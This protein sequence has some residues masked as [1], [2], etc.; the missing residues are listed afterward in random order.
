MF[1][2]LWNRLYTPYHTPFA[3]KVYPSVSLGLGRPILIQVGVAGGLL[4]AAGQLLERVKLQ[5]LL[6][7]QAD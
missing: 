1:H 2:R 7:Q 5:V 6:L 4:R 3:D